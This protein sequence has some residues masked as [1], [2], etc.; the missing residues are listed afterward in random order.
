MIQ[1]LHSAA[2]CEDTAVEP[3]KAMLPI[4]LMYIVMYTCKQYVW[5]VW[6]FGQLLPYPALSV[7]LVK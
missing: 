6:G 5:A 1:H 3:Y 7:C 4:P 2:V